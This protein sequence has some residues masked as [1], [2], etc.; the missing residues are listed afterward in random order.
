MIAIEVKIL[1]IDVKQT[2][3]QVSLHV[4]LL[5]L[6]VERKVLKLGIGEAA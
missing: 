2:L 5:N 6:L 3:N 1:I 4:E